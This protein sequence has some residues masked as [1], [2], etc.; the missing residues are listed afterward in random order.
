[1]NLA[2]AEGVA[3]VSVLILDV[4]DGS[5]Y[6]YIYSYYDEALMQQITNTNWY[7]T[8]HFGCRAGEF[9]KLSLDSSAT[10]N[11]CI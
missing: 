11:I 2:F 8:S 4:H 1:M 5:A 9:F 7:C 10:G 3:F 6:T